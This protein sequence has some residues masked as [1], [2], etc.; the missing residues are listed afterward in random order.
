MDSIT[1]PQPEVLKAHDPASSSKSSIPKSAALPFLILTLAVVTLAF[2]LGLMLG[3][4]GARRTASNARLPTPLQISLVRREGATTF[5]PVPLDPAPV[6]T[7]REPENG[8]R[9]NSSGE[10]VVYEK[11]KIIFRLQSARRVPG[12][13]LFSKSI[14]P[15]LGPAEI[16][17]P[18]AAEGTTT[19]TLPEKTQN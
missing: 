15:V 18:T 1:C 14:A 6:S 8:Q 10:L 13:G 5:F 9:T 4:S 19:S 17:R 12:T 7:A 16:K 11:G 3:W 2:C